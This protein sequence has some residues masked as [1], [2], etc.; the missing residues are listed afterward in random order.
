MNKYLLLLFMSFMVF[1]TVTIAKSQ[2]IKASDIPQVA[3]FVVNMVNK[4]GF[5][6]NEL[7]ALFTN[8]NLTIKKPKKSI[9]KRHHQITWDKFAKI[10]LTKQ[11][12]DSGVEFLYKHYDILQ[13]A[14]DEFGVQK[15]I[16]V[17][18]LGIE[19]NYGQDTGKYPVMKTLTALSFG[20]NRRQKFYKKELE[21]FLLMARN[22]NLAPLKVSGSYAGAMGIPQFISS[23]YNYYGIDFNKDGAVN[24]FDIE[25]SIGSIAN[26][27]SKHYWQKNGRFAIKIDNK[28]RNFATTKTSKPKLTKNIWVKKGV[29]LNE[30]YQNKKIALINFNNSS[31]IDTWATFWNFYVITR[32]NHDNKYALA[33]IKLAQ[34]IINKAQKI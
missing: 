16:I 4:H 8:I 2:T 9:N 14:E 7:D 21:E 20:K 12:I 29:I 19:T 13:R 30:V 5:V 31:T 10:F 22:N 25:D 23:S 33:A 24:L 3:S 15:A 28:Y 32:Y 11:R 27:F 34:K 6:K 18:I 26:Y 17:A 1:P